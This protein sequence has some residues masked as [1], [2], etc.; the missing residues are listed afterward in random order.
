MASYRAW[1]PGLDVVVGDFMEP[2]NVIE[3]GFVCTVAGKTGEEEPDW[4]VAVVATDPV[5]DGGVTWEARTATTITWTAVDLYK[6]GASEPTWSTT[7]GTTPPD[8]G[9]T[10]VDGT[11]SWTVRTPEIT[12]EACPHSAVAFAMASKVFSPY[13]DVVKYCATNAPRDWSTVDDAGF[14]PCGMQGLGSAEVTA[15]GEY[16]GR[17]AVFTASDGQLWTVDPDPAEMALF[18]QWRGIGVTYPDSVASVGNEMFF[19]A[20]D[21]GIRTLSVAVGATNIETNDVGAPVDPLVQ[22]Y[23][24][25]GQFTPHATYYPGLGQLWMAWGDDVL[26]YTSSRLGRM[27]SWSRY[28]LGNGGI[29]VVA[30]TQDDGRLFIRDQSDRV[31]EVDREVFSDLGGFLFGYVQTPYLT[32]DQPGRTTTLYSIDLVGVGS[33]SLEVGYLETSTGTVTDTYDVPAN[34]TTGNR[35]PVV[36]AGAS[37]DFRLLYGPSEQWEL[38][39]LD[40]EVSGS[41]GNP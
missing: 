37:M 15:L 24:D 8:F 11:V 19:V 26:V 40:V 10:P 2:A 13:K 29:Q 17:M 32:F 6:T 14:L 5:T 4:S 30:T 28:S 41:R 31:I 33:P 16:R 9:S 38:A 35:V 34:T 36:A 20:G 21:T 18:D 39:Y 23:I 22:E 7:V 27:G 25:A 3:F 1:Q 12:D